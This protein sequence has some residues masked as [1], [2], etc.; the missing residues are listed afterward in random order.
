MLKL[1]PWATT[2]TNVELNRPFEVRPH[3]EVSPDEVFL[4]NVSWVVMP[5]AVIMPHG[6]EFQAGR[7]TGE[8][9]RA[10]NEDI[11]QQCGI[12]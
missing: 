4:T 2:L 12:Q 1:K 5:V 7:V 11:R 6:A 8:I 10:L 9:I 3:P